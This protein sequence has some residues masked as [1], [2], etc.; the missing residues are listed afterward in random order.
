MVSSGSVVQVPALLDEELED[1]LDDELLELDED[2]DD[3]L[4][5]TAVVLELPPPPHAA[6]TE[7]DRAVMPNIPNSLR[8]GSAD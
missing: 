3:E 1:E 5:L 6:K 7:P 2:E 4:T 8:L